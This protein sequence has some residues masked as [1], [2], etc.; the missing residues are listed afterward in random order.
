MPKELSQ[1]L[2]QTSCQR[3]AVWMTAKGTV[4]CE[5]VFSCRNL[6]W[7]FPTFE[8]GTIVKLFRQCL[9]LLK[10]QM[11]V[12][13]PAFARLFWRV[14]GERVT[15]PCFIKPIYHSRLPNQWDAEESSV[16]TAARRHA[17]RIPA[18]RT[19]RAGERSTEAGTDQ[20]I[21]HRWMRGDR[22]VSA[23]Y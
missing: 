12:I 4:L 22:S 9:P 21:R 14:W 5:S 11:L 10:M 15:A 1:K 3:Q 23:G 20:S 13:N 6:S 2:F 18:A 19:R 16:S 7:L 8:D 17:G